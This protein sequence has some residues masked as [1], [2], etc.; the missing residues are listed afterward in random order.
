MFPK[1][2]TNN[3]TDIGLTQSKRF[4]DFTMRCTAGSNFTNFFYF[5]SCDFCT[6]LFFTTSISSFFYRIV[7][8]IFLSTEKQM[9]WIEAS[10]IITDMENGFSFIYSTL[11]K[12][13]GYSMHAKVLAS[14]K[15]YLPVS[16]T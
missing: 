3:S 15:T 10:P 12:G 5:F 2:F 6:P 14:S 16:F 9:I 1:F 7:D 4:S 11:K 8:V 13:I